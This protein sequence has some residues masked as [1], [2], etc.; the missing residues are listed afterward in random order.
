MTNEHKTKRERLTMR[1]PEDLLKWVRKFAKAKRK[2]V[3]QVVVDHFVELK[4]RH[5]VI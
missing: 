3:T 5:R 2:T 4:E 1:I